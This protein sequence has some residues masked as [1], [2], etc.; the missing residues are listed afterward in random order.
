V[1]VCQDR[2]D[3]QTSQWQ[4]EAIESYLKAIELDPRKLE[5]FL[6]MVTLPDLE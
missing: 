3:A 2:S 4:T 6:H 1:A 5:E